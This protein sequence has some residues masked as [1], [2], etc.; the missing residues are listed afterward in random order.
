MVRE[1]IDR[2]TDPASELPQPIL[3]VERVSKSYNPHK[4]LDGVSLALNRG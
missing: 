4:A 3:K 1:R 2:M